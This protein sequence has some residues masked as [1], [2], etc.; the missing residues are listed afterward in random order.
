MLGDPEP[1][2]DDKHQKDD[3]PENRVEEKEF[4]VLQ[5]LPS[6]F[7]Y[8]FQ[9]QPFPFHE[10][11]PFFLYT[12]T[13]LNIRQGKLCPEKTPLKLFLYLQK[14]FVIRRLLGCRV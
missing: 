9:A 12:I 2:Q 7:K 10:H 5:T 8:R 3:T 11:P 13:Q 14:D 6:F 1:V 4:E